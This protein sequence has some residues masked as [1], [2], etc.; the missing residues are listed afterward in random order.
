M[1]CM[2]SGAKFFYCQGVHIFEKLNPLVFPEI[3]RAYLFKF[4]SEQLKRRK[5]DGMHFC[6]PLYHMFFIFPEFF[7][8]FLNKN[9][10]FP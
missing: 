1:N 7:R 5:F 4:F 6:W 9:S 3:S 2:K 8:V 10:N